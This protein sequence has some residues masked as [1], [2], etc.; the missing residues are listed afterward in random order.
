VKAEHRGISGQ[1][2]YSDGMVEHDMHEG[3][4]LKLLD[5]LRIPEETIVF[6]STDTHYNTWPDA[7]TRCIWTGTTSFPC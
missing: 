1:D 6:Y 7:A 4:F 2:E 3:K 5:E